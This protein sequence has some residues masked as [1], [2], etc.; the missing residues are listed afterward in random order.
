MKNIF[1]QIYCPHLNR[2]YWWRRC[3]CRHFL[4][5]NCKIFLNTLVN[6]LVLCSSLHH[7]PPKRN[8]DRFTCCLWFH[9]PVPCQL[10]NSVK[11]VNFICSAVVDAPH[12]LIN[13]NE[14]SCNI[15]LQ[16]DISLLG[17]YLCHLS[18]QLQ[19]YSAQE[20]DLGY[21]PAYSRTDCTSHVLAEPTEWGWWL[22][23]V[24]TYPSN[25]WTGCGRS[26]CLSTLLS[27]CVLHLAYA[28]CN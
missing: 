28:R 13:C 16:P 21:L 14:S 4:P 18:F 2:T 26:L 25:W 6:I 15:E 11:D 20:E 8:I 10:V 23:L 12:Y 3:T 24:Q 7:V 17:W 5:F 9:K 22:H 1:W 27:L 19:R